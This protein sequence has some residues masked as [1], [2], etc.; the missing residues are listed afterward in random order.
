MSAAVPVVLVGHGR[1]AEGMRDAVELI[2]GAQDRVR[3]VGLAPAGDPD[4][5]WEQLGRVL[6][7]LGPR[8]AG[9]LVLADLAGGTPANVAGMLVLEDPSVQ[10]VGG[11]S[12]PMAL[13]VLTSPEETAERL[14]EVAVRAGAAGAVDVGARLRQAAGAERS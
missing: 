11:L 3:A 2:L 6:A 4:Q 12:L 5:L 7:E 10:L 9:V 14:A 1:L 13:E 8:P